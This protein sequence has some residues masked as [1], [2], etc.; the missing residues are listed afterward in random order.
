M[1]TLKEE[2]K[3]L[4]EVL[5]ADIVEN[6]LHEWHRK[7]VQREDINDT[8]SSIGRLSKKTGISKEKIL[9]FTKSFVEELF[10]EPLDLA[11]SKLNSITFD[12]S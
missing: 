8:K 9:E 10:Q 5:K 6:H 2:N 1:L 7:F 11:R 4:R 12:K 3:I